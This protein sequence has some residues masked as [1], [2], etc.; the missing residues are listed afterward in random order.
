MLV[1][2]AALNMTHKLTNKD[3]TTNNMVESL[4]YAFRNPEGEFLIFYSIFSFFM[5]MY[6]MKDSSLSEPLRFFMKDI[7]IPQIARLRRFD[8]LSKHLRFEIFPRLED[9]SSNCLLDFSDIEAT[10]KFGD[11]FKTK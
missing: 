9:G 11:A 8:P 3:V 7:I 5:F 6:S 10:D 1:I 4:A 2:L